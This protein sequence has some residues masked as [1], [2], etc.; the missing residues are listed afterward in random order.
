MHVGRLAKI[1]AIVIALA[2]P[3]VILAFWPLYLSK[4]FSTV[5]RY[6][7]LH[8][9]VGS[10]WLLLLILQP[11]AIHNGWYRLHVQI[12]KLSYVV[13]LIFVIA[14][15]LLSHQRLATMTDESFQIEGFGH[16]LPFYAVT[17]FA[18]AYILGLWY[19]RFD[20]V[21]ARF[22]LLTAI[23]LVDPVIGRLIFFYLPQLPSPWLYQVITFSLATVLA[24]LLVF[25][26]RGKGGPKRA[27][28]GYLVFLLAL[29]VGWFT[30]SVTST[31]KQIMA[32]YRS[33]PLT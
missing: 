17:V 8:A 30:V 5:D 15:L 32:F 23:P 22:M 31:W 2:T 18:V 20:E 16:Y 26:Y 13:A 3:L 4:S 14:G 25:S 9:I 10:L 28:I 21:H 12:G 24:A 33:L 6:S 7:H 19:R 1:S 27:L 11:M 29:E